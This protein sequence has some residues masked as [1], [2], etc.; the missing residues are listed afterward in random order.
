M[1]DR[2][3]EEAERLER[4]A[5]SMAVSFSYAD[6]QTSRERDQVAEAEAK[7]RQARK[8]ANIVIMKTLSDDQLSDLANAI[9]G[10]NK[11]IKFSLTPY[12]AQRNPNAYAINKAD[13]LIRGEQVEEKKV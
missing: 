12:Q 5:V 7:A 3:R 4:M 10:A 11:Q 6:T 2:L 9:H 8:N 13:E 1:I